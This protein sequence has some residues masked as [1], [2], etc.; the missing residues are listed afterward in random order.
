MPETILLPMVVWGAP[1]DQT[2]R[3]FHHGTLRN[4][5][6]GVVVAFRSR[7]GGEKGLKLK[8]KI[9]S[10][11]FF[12]TGKNVFGLESLLANQ[13]ARIEKIEFGK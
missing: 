2:G 4:H 11:F 7:P 12:L 3:Y 9:I 6:Q 8:K 13:I 5:F 10:I 1:L